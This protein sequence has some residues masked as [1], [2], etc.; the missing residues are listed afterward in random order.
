MQF[1]NILMTEKNSLFKQFFT[2]KK[3][4]CEIYKYFL[5]ITYNT[6]SAYFNLLTILFIYHNQFFFLL[7]TNT[8]NNECQK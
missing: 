6:H 4:R 7:K 2:Y 8:I 5:N 3:H 1:Y